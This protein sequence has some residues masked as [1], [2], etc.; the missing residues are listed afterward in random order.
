MHFQVGIDKI[1]SIYSKYLP[2]GGE[3]KIMRNF[4]EG[5]CFGA[6][7]TGGKGSV[8]CDDLGN[9][10]H[11]TV[12]EISAGGAVTKDPEKRFNRLTV[13]DYKEGGIRVLRD[14]ND[15][16][17][18]KPGQTLQVEVGSHTL[19]I[20]GTDR[21]GILLNGAEPTVATRQNERIRYPHT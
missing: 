3:I 5:V 18:L 10:L 6:K 19:T 16:P 8:V 12:A 21:Q 1:A 7:I 2:G 17:V 4:L 9:D 11:Y 15:N 20:E 13:E 14:V